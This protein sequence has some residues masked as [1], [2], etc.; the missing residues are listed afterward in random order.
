[1]LQGKFVCWD[2]VLSA[3]YNY[4]GLLETFDISISLLPERVRI[5]FPSGVLDCFGDE[6]EIIIA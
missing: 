5:L 6:W 2:L 3:K 4:V 1:M